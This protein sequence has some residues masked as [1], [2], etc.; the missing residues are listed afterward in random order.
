VIRAILHLSDV[1]A[2]FWRLEDVAEHVGSRSIAS[3]RVH[4]V[5]VDL[6]A[7]SDRDETGRGAR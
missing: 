6:Q 2:V 3:S 5:G 7:V 1:A 4:F